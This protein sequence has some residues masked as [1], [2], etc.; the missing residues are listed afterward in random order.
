MESQNFVTSVSVFLE[1]LEYFKER[2]PN[3]WRE[4]DFLIWMNEKGESLFPTNIKPED[5][6]ERWHKYF[7]KLLGYVISWCRSVNSE[8]QDLNTFATNALNSAIRL[9]QRLVSDFF[10]ARV[11]SMKAATEQAL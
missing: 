7:K 10:F 5:R 9:L 6:Q 3:E 11:S 2:K 1:Y 4:L 8:D